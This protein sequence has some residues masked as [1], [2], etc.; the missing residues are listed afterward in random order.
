M[1]SNTILHFWEPPQFDHEE[2]QRIAKVIYGLSLSIGIASLIG[3][4]GVVFAFEEKLISSIA[5]GILFATGVT[6]YILSKYG[7]IRVASIILLT[8]LWLTTIGI[9][10]V[11]GG[12]R[13]LD[14]LFFITG[15]A[16]AGLLLGQRGTIY[17][18]GLS[19]FAGI[20]FLI[21]ES[22]GIVLP[23]LF[24]FP[25]RTGLVMLLINLVILIPALNT[26][27]NTLHHAI[28]LANLRLDE[29]REIQEELRSSE[30][31]FSKAFHASPM[32]IIIQRVRDL[33]YVD[34]NEGF[35]R[36]TGYSREEA[37]EHTISELN[38]YPDMEISAQ[39]GAQL[40]EQGFI[41]DFEIPF[42]RKNGEIG[43]GLVWGE[44]IEIN[45]EAMY[46]A[47][48]IDITERKQTEEKIQQRLNEL[49]TVNAVSQVAASHIELDKL[50]GLTGERLRQIPN[51]DCLFIALYDSEA[52][53][54]SFPYY[55][56]YE[57]TIPTSPI[58][59][60]QGLT[61]RVI[62]NRKPL[63]INQNT[64]QL[65]DKSGTIQHNV[66][67][68]KHQPAKSW[69]GIPM[70]AGNQIIGVIG[71]QNFEHTNA[72][73]EDDVRLWET[74]AANIGIAIQNAQLYTAAQQEI[75]ERKKIESLQTEQA[76]ELKNSEEKFSK[77]FHASP[78]AIV[79]Q[80]ASDR[81]YIDVNEGFVKLTG[82]TREE[83]L[84]KTVDELGL[85][86][87][88]SVVEPFQREVQQEGSSREN[89]FPFRRK[90]GEIGYGIGWG[91]KIKMGGETVYMGGVID[92]TERKQLEN[93]QK[94]QA[95]D[96]SILYSALTKITGKQGDIKSLTKR[97]AEIIV[98]DFQAYECGVLLLTDDQSKIIR[99]AYCGPEIIEEEDFVSMDWQGL[100]TSAIKSGET[101]YVPDVHNDPRY[102]TGDEN[103][104]SEFVVP[105]QAYGEVIGVINMES[106]N[107][108]DFSERTRRLVS[109]FAHNA[110]L[111]LQN[112]KLLGSL[113][114]NLAELKES[115]ARIN[116]FLE[117]TAEGV[118]RIDY[119]PPIPV[120][121]P[122]EEQFKL[123]VEHGR[124][125]D[126]NEAFAHMYGFP[127]R[128]AVMG[129]PYIEFYGE[130]GYEAN[131]EGNLNFYR[132]G[133]RIDDLETEE[134]NVK[135]EKVYFTNNV[136]G[137]IRDGYFVSTWGTQRDI[138]QLKNALTEL[139][140]LNQELEKN[141]AELKE[142]QAR[143]NFFLE[144]TA[145]GVYRV[146]YDPP[147]PI[148]L[149]FE[150]QYKLSRERGRFGECNVA[151]A[152]MY[153]YST[154]EEML[155]GPYYRENEGTEASRKA[156]FDFYSRGY[157]TDDFETEEYTPA[158]DKA[159]FLNN[160]I[161]IIRDGYF[162]SIWGTQRDITPLKK[163]LTELETRNVELER[164]N[165]TLSHELKTPLVTI[166]GFLGF[167]ENDIK[168]G[169]IERAHSDFARIGH[170]VEKMY[171]MINEL[172]ELSRIGRLVNPPEDVSFEEIVLAGLSAV[173]TDIT[174]HNVQVHVHPNM[175]TVHVE[176]VRLIEVI[177]NLLENAIKY[178]G[179]QPNPQITIGVRSES[180]E[181]IFFVRDNGIGIDPAYHERVFNIFEKLN[182]QSEGTGIGLTI[183][184]RII[185]MH[186][187]R[188]W[189]ESDGPGKG[190]AFCFTLPEKTL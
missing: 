41:R 70:L 175:P 34:I 121:L 84:E 163:A 144:H 147:I 118:Y 160:A 68:K 35:T 33:K 85:Y 78:M 149:P 106:P 40:H 59:L 172:I 181:Q 11:S 158:G 110:T 43:Y 96:T 56:F 37:L 74:I 44:P 130:E 190:T 188:I 139:E 62:E 39:M 67:G 136:V 111:A 50:I 53:M 18:G 189:V 16:V 124:I 178:V 24:A 93:L 52:R 61:S 166:R 15:T 129:R 127:S 125:G 167:L 116:F 120:N 8:T 150:E 182:P 115:Q 117:H 79:I 30:E 141:L 135:G 12:M 54:I 152:R 58:P 90:N 51:V 113:E 29:Q 71:V 114:A 176:L 145:E 132:Q 87:D 128:E 14:I 82:Y 88:K 76:R 102:R 64:D 119:D 148:N 97:I 183:V 86:P 94:A 57:D 4:M 19:I 73:T 185:E 126:C 27:L 170:A 32:A 179:G 101:I 157:K 7:Y 26:T 99:K 122:I 168:T 173:E 137:I 98:N 134:F 89:E 95:Q 31:K 47:G 177:Q 123:S 28:E 2:T 20:I 164:F 174:K 100:T 36:I 92:I 169:N 83:A 156:N 48:T 80:R 72:Y 25:T 46:I 112:A 104:Q 165:Y 69:M 161:G 133:Y 131:L 42:R 77:A 155:N 107:L 103:T 180:G 1:K 171:K 143:I 23:H 60:G 186:G 159:Y 55:R 3:F 65:S 91:E 13:S 5:L 49:A 108:D 154:R 63:I 184:K 162:M 142:S 105:L 138:T 17:Y 6:A 21:L 146:D 153:G 22:T 9:V 45:G 75:A 81:R 109:T 151:I 187:G 66:P 140:R 38:I 10:T